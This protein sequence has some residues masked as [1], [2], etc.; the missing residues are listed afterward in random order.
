MELA[1]PLGVFL[2]LLTSATTV[3]LT[4]DVQFCV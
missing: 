2:F 3:A 1:F 4:Q